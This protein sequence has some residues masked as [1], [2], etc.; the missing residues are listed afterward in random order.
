MSS[1]TSA[2]AY[3][4]AARR[5]A[6]GRVGG[7]HRNRRLEDLTAPVVQAALSDARIAPGRVDEV[8]IG[9]ASAGGNPA[10]LIALAAGLPET[11]PALT[12]DR[13]C[14]SG[15]DAILAAIR[16]ISAGEAEVV[17]AGGAES[18]STAPWRIARPRSPYQLPRFI[19]PEQAAAGEE[20][21]VFEASETLA[22]RRRITRSAQ[23]AFTL[24]SHLRAESAR[25]Q[26][27]FVGEIVPI[28]SN[29]EEAR[30]QSAIGPSLE[31]LE[32]VSPYTPPKG[33][34][35]P[36]N[37]STLHD[38]AAIVVVVSESVW[39]ELGRPRALR[40]VTSAA[41]GVSP[42]AEAD[43]PILA[44]QKLYKRLNG[45][46]RSAIGVVEMSENSAAQAIALLDALDLEEGA[47][48]PGG[49]AVV[50]GHPLGASGA[51][52]VVR[53]FTNLV[54][55]KKNE[56]APYGAVTQGTIGGFGV[57]ALFEAVGPG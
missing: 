9:N 27:H 7:L 31:D 19:G 40:L 15:L 45:F 57:A 53:L 55:S 3:I 32:R 10:R 56:V 25:E 5:S 50:R 34:L 37:T 2:S 41:Q 4:V 24:K 21:H 38:G 20:R 33:T 23:D 54:R 49:G 26:R 16:S 44:M 36:G 52:L 6:L 51:V 46:D 22:R 8:I 43:A 18:L 12:L 47:L 39:L 17:V 28:R 35:T 1:P 48:N 30:D 42:G 29:P 13:Q 11:V 14:G